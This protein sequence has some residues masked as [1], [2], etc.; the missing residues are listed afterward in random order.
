[1]TETESTA[2]PT[3]LKPSLPGFLLRFLGWLV[4]LGFL[5]AWLTVEFRGTLSGLLE[6]TATVSGAVASVFANTVEWSGNSVVC[7]GFPVTIISECTGLLEMV[8][9][10]C[11]VIGYLSTVRSKLIGLI[12]GNILIYIL[13]I[14][15]IVVL[16]VAGSYSQDTFDFMHLCTF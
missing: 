6:F 15:R 9:F 7:D 12:V 5:Y 16:L 13:N 11:A 10:S 1:M 4:V 8:I 14:I 3:E 2:E